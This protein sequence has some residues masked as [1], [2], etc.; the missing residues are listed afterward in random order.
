MPGGVPGWLR[1]KY[2]TLD[3][4]NRPGESLLG[5]E[6]HRLGPD[7]DPDGSTDRPWVMGNPGACL[8]WKRFITWQQARFQADQV[9]ILRAACPDDFVTHNFMGLFQ[10]LDYYAMAED[11]DF[12]SW[13]NYPI[14]SDK[15]DIPYSA[16]LAADLMR[17]LKRKNFMIMEQTAGPCGWEASA[18]TPGRGRSARSPTSNWPTARTGRSGSAGGPAPSGASSTGTACSATTASRCAAT[19]RP[20]RRRKEFRRSKPARHHG[21]LGRCDYLR[22]R[23]SVVPQLP[24]GLCGQQLPAAIRRYY[25]ALFRAG[26]NVDMVNRKADLRSTSWSSRPTCRSCPTRPPRSWTPT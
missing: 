8:D 25:D 1:D 19:G 18:A 5:P 14:W 2:G 22:L 16:S 9:K 4:L 21:R 20:R 12:V 6:V 24:A 23:L 11:L 26:V 10:R 13:D 3:A 17:G 15:P 7:H